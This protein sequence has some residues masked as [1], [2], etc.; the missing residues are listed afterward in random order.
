MSQL[1]PGELM[2]GFRRLFDQDM[3]EEQAADWLRQSS[4]PEN[5]PFSIA[6][7]AS[8]LR[9]SAS[10]SSPTTAGSSPVKGRDR[11]RSLY[12]TAASR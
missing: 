6:A 10:N 5:L 4:T 1:S 7:A 3:S 9:T 12:E 8:I 11:S 2:H